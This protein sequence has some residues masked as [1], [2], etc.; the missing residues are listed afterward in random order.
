MEHQDFIDYHLRQAIL[1]CA[2]EAQ[3]DDRL[4]RHLR[5]QMKLRLISMSDK[6]LWKLATRLFYP[7]TK[8][9]E[10]VYEELKQAIAQHV[11]NR[12]DWINDLR[13]GIVSENHS[14]G[15]E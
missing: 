14:C 3:N 5:A 4:S 15:S 9:T 13:Q 12:G 8:S 11:A 6:E 10:A 7:L 2:A 1:I